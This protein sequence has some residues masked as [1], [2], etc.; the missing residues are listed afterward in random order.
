M[1]RGID[2]KT[3]KELLINGFLNDILDNISDINLKKFLENTLKGQI[4]GY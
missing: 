4:D 2:G 1:T 3:A